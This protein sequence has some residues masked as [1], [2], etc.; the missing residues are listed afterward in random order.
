[1]RGLL[2]AVP[3]LLVAAFLSALAPTT[4]AGG[5]EKGSLAVTAVSD[6]GTGLGGAVAGRPFSVVVQSRDDTGAPLALNRATTVTLSEV[7]GDGDLSGNLSA[8]I[9]R[10]GSQ[11]TITGAVYSA[12]DNGVVL[13]VRASGGVALNPGRTT[14]DI[15]ATAVRATGAPRSGIEVTDPACTVPTATSPTCGFLR[16]PNGANGTILLSVGSCEGVVSC[17]A[18][19]VDKAGLVTALV[20]LKD[21]FGAPLYTKTAPA[22]FVLACDKSLC[23]NGGV[24]SFDVLVD[25]T[26][27]GPLT[28]APRCPAKGELG[29][30]QSACLDTVQS[31]RDGAG[32]LYSVILLDFD[33]RM[34]HP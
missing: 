13:E 16:L 1:L 7:S 31:K 21:E 19:S 32:D 18:D 5:P 22:T 29:P 28:V 15:A 12:F 34:S 27:Q 24:P 9:P 11:A 30:T 4:A 6:T 25:L 14:V 26:N 23:S 20:D 3:L 17:R 33:V 8:V 10:N 2:T